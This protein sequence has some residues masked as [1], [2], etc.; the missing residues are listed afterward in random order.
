MSVHPGKAGDQLN[1]RETAGG[2]HTPNSSYYHYGHYINKR[3]P[4]SSEGDVS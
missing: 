2:L 1:K 3:S 4:L